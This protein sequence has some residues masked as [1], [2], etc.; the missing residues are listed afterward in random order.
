[1]TLPLSLLAVARPEW[2]FAAGIVLAFW[3][4]R[5]SV[6]REVTRWRDSA[7]LWFGRAT[8]LQGQV[9]RLNLPPAFHHHPHFHATRGIRA[10]NDAAAADQ[11]FRD[12]G[13]SRV[14]DV[15]EAR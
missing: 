9:N 10:V 11:L 5:S 3:L 12:A 8:E 4:G 14:V 6:R 15:E 1:M 13:L 7:D 2:L